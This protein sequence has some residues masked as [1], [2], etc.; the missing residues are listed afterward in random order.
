MRSPSWIVSFALCVAAVSLTWTPAQAQVLPHP[1]LDEL[2]AE[3]A[4]LM[5]EAALDG[6]LRTASATRQ[7]VRADGT[8]DPSALSIAPWIAGQ[9]DVSEGPLPEGIRALSERLSVGTLPAEPSATRLVFSPPRARNDGGLTIMTFVELPPFSLTVREFV[10]ARTPGGW[11]A[12][13]MRE[14]ERRAG[15]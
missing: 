12:F 7:H 15:A 6:F 4:S 10:V 1:S 14:W 5:Y 3:H 13:T 2:S 11:T 9:Q 8:L